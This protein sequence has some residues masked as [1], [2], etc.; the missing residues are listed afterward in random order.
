MH[1]L[2]GRANMSARMVLIFIHL[3]LYSTGYAMTPTDT[4]TFR[5]ATPDD[6]ALITRQ[7]RWMFDEIGG[8]D[9]V[10]LDAMDAEF[11]GW[12]RERLITGEYVGWFALTDTG[13][14]IAGAGIWVRDGLPNPS[15]ATGNRGH[16][17]N[18]YT[19]PVYRRNKL[20]RRLMQM[21][22]AWCHDQGIHGVTLNASRF[23]RDLYLSLGFENDNTMFKWVD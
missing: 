18:V 22:L 21:I 14:P 8:H 10:K 7:R 12:V 20:A 1:I 4:F 5:L 19:D 6:A 3:H 15:Q 23:G 17:V 11:V 16:I 9:P 2:Y 13:E